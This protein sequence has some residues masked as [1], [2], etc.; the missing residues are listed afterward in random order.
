MPR[1]ATKPRRDRRAYY[2]A[3]RERFLAK[4]KAYYAANREDIL[5]KEK[6]RYHANAEVR[7]KRIACAAQ[8]AKDHPED[9]RKTQQQWREEH[10]DYQREWHAE[11]PNY[12]AEWRA[13]NRERCREYGRRWREKRKAE[14]LAEQQVVVARSI[15][16]TGRIIHACG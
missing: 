3:N 8:W 1:T 4:R 16:G 5:A 14:R 2:Q 12:A 11:H 7:E 9:Y 13:K 15:T 6:Q 10:P